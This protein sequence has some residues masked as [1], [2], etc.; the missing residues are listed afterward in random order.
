MLN[1]HNLDES[2]LEGLKIPQHVAIIMDGNGRW[3]KKRGQIRTFGHNEGAKTIKKIAE[4]ADEIGIKYL[5]CYAFS[6]ENWSRPKAEV[7]FLMELLIRSF[8]KYKDDIMEKNTKVRVI[9]DRNGVPKRVLKTID[10]IEKLT[11]DN[12]RL[13]LN[14]AFNYGGRREIAHA[15]SKLAQAAVEGKLKPEDITEEVFAKALYLPNT[16][17]PDLLIRSSG[18]KRVSNFLLWEIAYTEFWTSDI[19][20]PDFSKEA[21]IQAI[22]DYN[23]RDRRFGGLKQ[24]E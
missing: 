2:D 15:A 21:L 22:I 13:Q 20:W 23:D 17:D 16:P 4:A 12:D 5:T 14:I 19:L 7:E 10:E 18:E 6:T 24:D 8:N 9:G 1:K 11:K 3:A